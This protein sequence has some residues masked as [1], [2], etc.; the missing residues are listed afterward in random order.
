MLKGQIKY[1][2]RKLDSVQK[3]VFSALLMKY[4]IDCNISYSSDLGSQAVNV[5]FNRKLLVEPVEGA[6]SNRTR[7]TD[8]PLGNIEIDESKPRF[9]KTRPNRSYRYI[10]DESFE[11]IVPIP[12]GTDLTAPN[13]AE[14]SAAR[15]RAI[16]WVI[17]T[18]SKIEGSQYLEASYAALLSRSKIARPLAMKI[19]TSNF[20]ARFV[21]PPRVAPFQIAAAMAVE[22]DFNKSQYVKEECTLCSRVE[23]CYKCECGC[24]LC[25]HEFVQKFNTVPFG[26]VWCKCGKEVFVSDRKVG[27]TGL[28]WVYL[29]G[30]DPRPFADNIQNYDHSSFCLNQ[31]DQQQLDMMLPFLADVAVS[32]IVGRPRSSIKT[33]DITDSSLYGSHFMPS[34]S[35][36][37]IEGKPPGRLTKDMVGAQSSTAVA[38]FMHDLYSML[39]SGGATS[40]ECTQLCRKWISNVFVS[41]IKV[42]TIAPGIDEKGNWKTKEKARIF[43][44]ENVIGYMILRMF[45]CN[46]T[47]TGGVR[48][49]EDVQPCAVGMTFAG[50]S[51][52]EFFKEFYDVSEKDLENCVTDSDAIN[53]EKKILD[54]YLVYESDAKNY[55]QSLLMITLICCMAAVLSRY[56]V[57]RDPNDSKHEAVIKE[58]FRYICARI[59]EK[60]G[61]KVVSR[62]D[63]KGFHTLFG[64]MASGSYETSFLNTVVNLV[65]HLIVYSQYFV[66]YEKMNLKSAMVK[67]AEFLNEGHIR[68]KLFGDDVLAAHKKKYFPQ[69]NEDFYRTTIKKFCNTNIPV[70][71]YLEAKHIF[72]TDASRGR[73]MEKNVPSFLKFQLMWVKG[74]IG[75]FRHSSKSIPK[76]FLSSDTELTPTKL[77][78]RAICLM[79]TAGVNPH[80][81]RACVR[82]IYSLR[83]SNLQGEF[84]DLTTNLERFGLDNNIFYYGVPSYNQVLEFHVGTSDSIIPKRIRTYIDW[85]MFCHYP[86]CKPRDVSGDEF[87]KNAAKI[88]RRVIAEGSNPKFVY[89]G[90]RPAGE[91]LR[92]K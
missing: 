17:Q 66:K 53:L 18:G 2:Y 74:D 88:K 3:M 40:G 65:H 23:Y 71:E 27:R 50:S 44:M 57:T 63:G 89:R 61:V 77:Y 13:R 80:T 37:A 32:K 12:S 67:A 29:A 73:V 83:V 5:Q 34:G 64:T 26:H 42:E 39:A 51:A 55:D 30:H 79:W 58:M 21:L 75:F 69:W 52:R 20:K 91:I 15:E 19:A 48:N 62:L 41:A 1:I 7:V 28:D 72:I 90:G 92:I 86:G 36:G 33:W 46:F 60:V 22:R 49:K 82:T 11:V 6:N 38:G 45:I 85:P 35:V 4:S 14:L 70:G 81:Y 8:H 78:Q 10:P 59:V 9:S 47:Q 24:N 68:F 76:L 43:H 25:C 56:D 16:E 87:E 54:E 31:R 84:D